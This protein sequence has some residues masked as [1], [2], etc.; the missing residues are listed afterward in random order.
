LFL[1][2][3]GDKAEYFASWTYVNRK[4]GLD[5]Q[6]PPASV[7]VDGDSFT[8]SVVGGTVPPIPMDSDT[9]ESWVQNQHPQI[10]GEIHRRLSRPTDYPPEDVLWFI[11]DQAQVTYGDTTFWEMICRS[12]DHTC[13]RI[14]IIA[15][16]CY[17]SLEHPSARSPLTSLPFQ[18]RI[19]LFKEPSQSSYSQ[20]SL[21]FTYSDFEE[22][23][24][25]VDAHN[26]LNG[27]IRGSI[28]RHA[29]SVNNDEALPDKGKLCL[30]EE[31]LTNELLSGEAHPGVV[32]ALTRIFL[33][34]VCCLCVRSTSALYLLYHR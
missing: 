11:L 5:S 29:S 10:W 31:H 34:E 17:G 15:A 13:V 25:I 26:T 27:S 30:Y 20:L 22:Y 33:N 18:C 19:L 2:N 16:G 8:S 32:K 7:G 21:A 4:P 23:L 24:K 6:F 28:F 3:R 12:Y 1:K 14:R 9:K